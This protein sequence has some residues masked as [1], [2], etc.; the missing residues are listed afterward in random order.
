MPHI[1]WAGQPENRRV[2]WSFAGKLSPGAGKVS[3]RA[4][5]V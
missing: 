5:K 2:R 4:G 1:M 3:L